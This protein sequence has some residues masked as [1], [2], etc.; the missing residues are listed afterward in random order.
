MTL[1]PF[2]LLLAAAVMTLAQVSP[3]PDKPKEKS[4]VEGRVTSLATGEP[5]RKATLRLR[6]TMTGPTTNAADVPA[7]Q[8]T[9]DNEGKFLFEDIEPGRYTLMAER[10]GFV[11][12]TY[13]ASSPTRPGTVL[14]LDAGQH[15]KDVLFK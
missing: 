5:V 4:K 11:R 15:L 7:Y 9:T 13:G 8:S 1:R 6:G 10:A 12:Q 2:G 3:N 14:T